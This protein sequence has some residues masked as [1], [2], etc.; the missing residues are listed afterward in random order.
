M[1]DKRLW[2]WRFLDASSQI[3]NVGLFNGDP[4]E[5]VSA[6]VYRRK[7]RR[8]VK[9]INTVFFWQ[10]DHCRKAFE[11]DYNRNV[12]YVKQYKTNL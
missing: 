12:V 4:N 10:D 5:S 8:L 2:I 1:I 7:H 3:L 6:R 9:L 11:K